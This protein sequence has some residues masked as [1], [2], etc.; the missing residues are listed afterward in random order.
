MCHMWGVISD[1]FKNDRQGRSGEAS[2]SSPRTVDFAKAS[3]CSP[4]EPPLFDIH[5]QT[6]HNAF[7][8]CARP[9]HHPAIR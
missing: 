4:T 8:R 2:E 9:L 5:R 7:D 6:I 3:P 1:G